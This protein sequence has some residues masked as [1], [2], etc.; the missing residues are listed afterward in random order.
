VTV[1]RKRRRGPCR[2]V[3]RATIQRVGSRS[4]DVGLG[5]ARRYGRA[6]NPP[7]P[8]TASFAAGTAASEKVSRR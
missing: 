2:A 7:M 5:C 1:V 6:T 3:N 4:Y 8:A